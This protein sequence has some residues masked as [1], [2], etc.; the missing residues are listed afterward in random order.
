MKCSWCNRAGDDL[1]ELELDVPNTLGFG[2]HPERFH[3][4]SD[5]EKRLRDFVA[6]TRRYAPVF[7]ILLAVLLAISLIGA[8]VK[9]EIIA[10][11]AIAAVGLTI[12]ALPFST[13]QTVQ[14]LGVRTSVLVGR[15][16]G[17]LLML[18]GVA[19]A[20]DLL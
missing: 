6:F 7:I 2:A 8:A 17:T 18:M 9:Q 15:V 4:H 1:T 16:A 3:V 5:H 12:V 13:H 11:G 10:D 19:M 20:L 14:M